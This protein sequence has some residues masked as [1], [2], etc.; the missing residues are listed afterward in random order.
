MIDILVRHVSSFCTTYS[1]LGMSAGHILSKYFQCTGWESSPLVED[2][3]VVIMCYVINTTGVTLSYIYVMKMMSEQIQ[4]HITSLFC[5]A[6]M[7]LENST[8]YYSICI[9]HTND[10]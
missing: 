10:I 9:L 7:L 1:A 5:N 2:C 6:Y 8:T 4:Q 3:W